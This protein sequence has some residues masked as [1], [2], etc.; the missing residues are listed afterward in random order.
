M[1]EEGEAVQSACATTQQYKHC[2]TAI[3]QLLLQ[4][5]GEGTSHL[6]EELHRLL[7]LSLCLKVRGALNHERRGGSKSESEVGGQSRGESK[8]G[9]GRE[10]Q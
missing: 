6:V 7:Q 1:T 8:G 2:R 3:R 4:G 10:T 5:A 9:R